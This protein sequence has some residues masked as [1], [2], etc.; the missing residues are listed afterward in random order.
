VG[1]FFTHH[2]TTVV[3]S[4]YILGIVIA[5]VVARVLRRI[6]FTKA[7]SPLIMELPAYHVPSIKTATRSA[8]IRTGFFVKKAGTFIFG[9]VLVIWML[10]SLP[11][12]VGYASA[13]SII[14]RIGSAMAPVFA[15]AG[16]ASW[17]ASVAL[18]FGFLAKEVVVGTLGT[19]YGGQASLSSAIGSQFSALSAMS[20]M[21]MTLV[22]IPC[23]ST[24]AVIRREIGTKWAALSVGVSV[25]LGYVLAVL[26]FQAGRFLGI[27]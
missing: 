7:V 12:G 16:F 2:Q 10:A 21:V 3:F 23:V 1:V 6:F 4:L 9:A 18:I 5:I 15:P 11:A 27:G 20:F 26:V 13:E 17:Q 19:L 24:I 25:T 8:G 22:Y 14:G